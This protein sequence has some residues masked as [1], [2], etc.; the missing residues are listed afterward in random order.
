MSLTFRPKLRLI[1]FITLLN[2]QS[3]DQSNFKLMDHDC[4]LT[5]DEDEPV[6]EPKY[7]GYSLTILAQTM[8]HFHHFSNLQ[9]KSIRFKFGHLWMPFLS[10]NTKAIALLFWLKYGIHIHHLSNLQLIDFDC[11][12]QIWSFVGDV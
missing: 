6:F 5:S 10:Q 1:A 7:Q 9:S 3:K 8:A 11:R 4:R 12:F 2:L